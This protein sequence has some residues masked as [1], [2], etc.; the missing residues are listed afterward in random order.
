MGYRFRQLSQTMPRPS[1]FSYLVT[2]VTAVGAMQLQMKPCFRFSI[3]RGTVDLITRRAFSQ[4]TTTGVILVITSDPYNR[5]N[6]L[7]K[8][9]NLESLAI[10]SNFTNSMPLN[11]CSSKA[12]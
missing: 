11:V 4:A 1:A 7:V 2:A 8:D 6:R 3:S 9:D 5:L 10:R 12:T